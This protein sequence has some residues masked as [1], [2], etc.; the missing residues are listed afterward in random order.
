MDS[1]LEFVMRGG[2]TVTAGRMEAF[3]RKIPFLKVK[4]ETL[5]DPDFPHLAEQARFLSRYA[6]DVLDGQYPCGDLVAITET[7]FALGY[8]LRDVDIIPDDVPGGLTDDSLVLRAA[9]QGHEAEFRAFAAAADWNYNK[10][11]GSA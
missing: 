6:E 11:T 5:T 1:M 9:L 8:L 7:V 10:V 4:A 2:Q 3:R